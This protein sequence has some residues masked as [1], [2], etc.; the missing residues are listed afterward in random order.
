MRVPSHTKPTSAG[1]LD[2][3]LLVQFNLHYF[4][5]QPRSADLQPIYFPARGKKSC[6]EVLI[7]SLFQSCASALLVKV[8][9]PTL[10]LLQSDPPNNSDWN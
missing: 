5:L 2:S 9:F 10:T 8:D 4:I 6:L 1:Y 7:I 3:V